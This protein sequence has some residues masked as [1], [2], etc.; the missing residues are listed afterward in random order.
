MDSHEILNLFLKTYAPHYTLTRKSMYIYELVADIGGNRYITTINKKYKNIYGEFFLAMLYLE[1]RIGKER[2]MVYDV[3][4]SFG[5]Y[6][7]PVMWGVGMDRGPDFTEEEEEL[8]KKWFD[9]LVAS[10]KEAVRLRME[11]KKLEI[12]KDYFSAIQVN[13]PDYEME[14]ADGF[15][16]VNVE[17]RGK[18]YGGRIRIEESQD[19]YLA[20]FRGVVE[21]VKK[22][23]PDIPVYVC[24]VLYT[25]IPFVREYKSVIPG[26]ESI[27]D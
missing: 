2:C 8:K 23:H 17:I 14:V 20:L 25:T 18:K 9:E 24:V 10:N 15:F 6:H 1:A 11:N 19:C 13:A 27:E 21:Q 16:T 12:F 5:G 26:N 3:T 7:V 22:D 4:V